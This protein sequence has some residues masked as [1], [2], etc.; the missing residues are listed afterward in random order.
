MESLV[1]IKR[2]TAQRSLP[3]I[4]QTP[5]GNDSIALPI[6]GTTQVREIVGRVIF[7]MDARRVS[8]N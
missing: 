8:K 6:Q 4:A 1:I 5:L 7:F 3:L 2:I